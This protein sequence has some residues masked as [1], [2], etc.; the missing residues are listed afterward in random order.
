M[1]KI[2]FLLL[3]TIGTQYIVKAQDLFKVTEKD[4]DGNWLDANGNAK[5]DY[6]NNRIA[7][8]NSVLMIDIE[9]ENIV[10]SYANNKGL[11][12]EIAT[13]ITALKNVL[14]TEK[15]VLEKIDNLINRIDYSSYSKNPEAIHKQLKDLQILAELVD[16]ISLIDK[17]IDNIADSFYDQTGTDGMFSRSYMAA[18]VVLKREQAKLFDYAKEE[19]VSIKF[20]AWLITKREKIPLHIDGFDNIAPQQQYE[21]ERWAISLTPEQKQELADLQKYAKENR[22]KG[23]DLINQMADMQ[24][25]AIK[26]LAWTE[27]TGIADQIKLE[28]KKLESDPSVEDIVQKAKTLASDIETFKKDAERRIAY[29]KNLKFQKGE[30]ITDLVSKIT[31]DITYFSTTL[32]TLKKKA[33]DLKSSIN[34][35]AINLSPNIT[36]TF[37][38]IIANFTTK[39]DAINNLNNT[40]IK[41]IIEG[42]K[43]D[44]AALEFSNAVLKLS[45][46]EIKKNFEFDLTNA[47]YREEGNR[48]ALK[49][50]VYDKSSNLEIKTQIREI[51]LFK[52]LTHVIST[53]GIVFADPFTPTAIQTQFQMAPYYNLLFKG[54]IDKKKRRKSITYNKLLD[55][56]I[57]LHVSAPD[58]DKD[59][60]PELGA[61]IVI[62]AL[63]DYVQ[64]GIAYN[65]FTGDPYWFFGLRIP[66]PSFGSN[67]Q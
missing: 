20:G 59:D 46:T 26:D 67:N 52:V 37:S 51:Y 38:A 43:L 57:G 41:D 9:A 29:Y 30:N 54:W 60:V 25:K 40:T 4:Q 45:L 64:S 24:I 47:G 7:D 1:K 17:D 16:N 10:S 23:L 27:Y 48:V 65:I 14:Q 49:L 13:K 12:Q 15:D 53:V 6:I 66:M 5:T 8:I 3:L 31:S 18:A 61:G 42:R 2:L 56:G 44:A 39:I 35:T 50:S 28:I 22:D 36:N 21:V 34:R 11:P 63:H 55:W 62:T 33:S 32:E 58:F 19:G